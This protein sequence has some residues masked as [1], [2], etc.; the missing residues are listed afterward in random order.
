[1]TSRRVTKHAIFLLMFLLISL[2]TSVQADVITIPGTATATVSQSGEIVVETGYFNSLKN[3][4]WR[5]TPTPAAGGAGYHFAD[6][7]IS[8]PINLPPGSKVTS[9]SIVW[10][11]GTERFSIK[12]REEDFFCGG[13]PWCDDSSVSIENPGL[14]QSFVNFVRSGT[15]THWFPLPPPRATTSG[16]R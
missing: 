11:N 6:W 10:G 14:T 1:M 4:Y 12:T 9:A 2:G 8:F 5:Q 15:I 16:R 13:T 3:V 7:N